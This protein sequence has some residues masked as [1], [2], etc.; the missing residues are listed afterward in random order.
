MLILSMLLPV[1]EAYSQLYSKVQVMGGVVPAPT[2]SWRLVFHDEFLGNRLDTSKWVTYYPYDAQGRDQCAYCRTHGAEGQVYLDE[3]VRISKGMATL[4]VRRD[5]VQWMGAERAYSSGMLHTRP[6]WKFKYGRFEIRCRLPKGMGF[7]PAFWL[8]G[9]GGNE[10]DI[11]ELGMQFPDLQFTN[12]HR[13]YNGR[14]YYHGDEHYGPDFSQDF[15][16]FALEWDPWSIRWLVDGYPVRQMTRLMEQRRQQPV[17]P[18][19]TL[20]PGVYLENLLMPEWPLDVIVNVAAGVTGVTPFT[21]SPNAETIFPADM[22][23]DYVRV[24]QRQPQAGFQDLC[25]T[26]QVTGPERISGPAMFRFTGP[27]AAL[28]WNV[29]EGLI[30]LERTVDG[31]LIGPLPGADDTRQWVEAVVDSAENGPC[32][33]GKY[34][35]GISRR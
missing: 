22:L 30:I 27:F 35:V 1:A 24:Y 33:G 32:P 7:W 20:T 23:V 26:A 21:D 17:L 25:A 9:W 2:E 8:Y 31:I 16:V 15:H 18:G 4:R 13:D 28:S 34:R 3:N 14:H 11:F 10:I 5:S 12:I 6:P 19:T 29:S